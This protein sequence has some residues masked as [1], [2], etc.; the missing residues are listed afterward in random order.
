MS[1]TRL[2]RV[3]L[4]GASALAITLSLSISQA[5]AQVVINEDVLNAL[6]GGGTAAGVPTYSV[7]GGLQFPP[8][9]MP[10]SFSNVSNYAAAQP[11][12][13]PAPQPAPEPAAQ[14]EPAPLPSEAAQMASEPEDMS[15]DPNAQPV[16]EPQPAP[17]PAA[18]AEV[19]TPPSPPEPEPA[20]EPQPAPEPVAE[21][22]PVPEPAPEPE[23]TA[24][25]AVAT[26]LLGWK[27]QPSFR[28]VRQRQRGQFLPQSRRSLR[29]RKP[30]PPRLPPVSAMAVCA[31]SSQRVTPHCRGMRK[32]ACVN[33][34][35]RCCRMR[36]CVCSFS[37]MRRVATQRPAV[38]AAY[39]CRAH[40]R[41]VV[42]SSI[43]VSAR[44]AWTCGPWVTISLRAVAQRTAST[45]YQLTARSRPHGLSCCHGNA[46]CAL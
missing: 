7:Y 23:E 31:L 33:L 36:P 10:R 46:S 35:S 41:Y 25:A 3:A 12:A 45:S 2:R 43:R 27:Q 13:Q 38:R 17:E 6:G 26:P 30:R 1:H 9:Q 40:W 16:P 39:P 14:P 28:V 34:P 24:V 44:L 11:A 32:A 29:P 21:P 15:A 20:P 22:E 19:A 37:P 8:Q 42:S 5:H 4:C 18:A